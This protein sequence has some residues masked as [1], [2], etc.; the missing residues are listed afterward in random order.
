MKTKKITIVQSLGLTWY[1]V[2]RPGE[3]EYKYLKE[4]FNFHPLDIQ[5][6]IAPIQRPKFEE[7]DDYI[8]LVIRLPFY[9]KNE[10][11]ISASEMDIF[12]GQDFLVTIQRGKITTHKS[13]VQEC[14]NFDKIRERYV[15]QGP[16]YLLYEILKRMFDRYYP[17]LDSVGLEIDRIDKKMYKREEREIVRIIANV[18]RSVINLRKILRAHQL[19][20]RKIDQSDHFFLNINNLQAKRRAMTFKDIQEQIINIWDILEVHADTIFSLDRTNE[21]LISHRLN[22]IMKTLTIISAIFLPAAL[23]TQFFG[24]SFGEAPFTK[25]NSG[26]AMIL[27]VIIFVSAVMLYLFKKKRWL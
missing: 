1:D 14:K 13:F 24:I 16:G 3:K 22:Q 18:K 5:D 26:V 6:C 7:Y 27:F 19:V 9:N 2:K 12:I 21:S 10:K 8:F 17:L 4:K 20:I 23:I 25:S 11:T 15:G